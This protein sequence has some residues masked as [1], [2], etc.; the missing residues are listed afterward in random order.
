[1]TIRVAD[2]VCTGHFLEL[3]PGTRWLLWEAK[4]CTPSNNTYTHRA[5]ISEPILVSQLMMPSGLTGNF[6]IYPHNPYIV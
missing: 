2:Q 1:M 5:P 3:S 4:P 6:G